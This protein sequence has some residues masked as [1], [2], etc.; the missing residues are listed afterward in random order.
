MCARFSFSGMP[1]MSRLHV[2]VDLC[3]DLSIILMDIG[4][5][6]VCTL[7]TGVPGR[8][9]FLVAPVSDMASCLNICI[10]DV[11]YAVSIC[12]LV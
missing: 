3:F 2:C 6:D 4:L 1:A 9:K 12:L 7:F 5:L 11:D 8:T 10:I